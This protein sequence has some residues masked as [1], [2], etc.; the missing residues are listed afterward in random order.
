MRMLWYR[1]SVNLVGFSN[2][3]RG[4]ITAAQLLISTIISLERHPK[5]ASHPKLP[6]FHP[7]QGTNCLCSVDR[8]EHW[9]PSGSSSLIRNIVNWWSMQA[10]ILHRLER[11]ASLWYS[12]WHQ[13]SAES[14]FLTSECYAWRDIG[15]HSSIVA[16]PMILV[17]REEGE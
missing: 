13:G 10:T 5:D 1:V 8:S 16:G 4:L 11:E 2:T 15:V 12:E 6:I 17:H 9:G 3:K 14:E 7:V